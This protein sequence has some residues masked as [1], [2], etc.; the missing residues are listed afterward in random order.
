VHFIAK[1]A[2]LV[3]VVATILLGIKGL[4]GGTIQRAHAVVLNGGAFIVDEDN[5]GPFYF[6]GLRI[7]CGTAD[8]NDRSFT[9]CHSGKT[10]NIGG[11]FHYTWNCG[12]TSQFMTTQCP[13]GANY[14]FADWRPDLWYAANYN[15]CVFLPPD[16]A[17]T[18]NAQYVVYSAAGPIVKSVNQQSTPAS[19]GLGLGWYSLGVFPFNAGTGGFVRLG[20]YTGE[21]QATTQIGIDA[22]EF[23]LDGASCGSAA[24]QPD[25]DRDRV[26]DANDNC[27]SN[28]NQGQQNN[29]GDAQGDAC[30]PDDDN[31]SLADVVETSTGSYVS[32]SDTG[33]NPFVSDT[34]VDGLVDGAEVTVY[35]T[36]PTKADSDRDT[37]IDGSEVAIG[38][39]P[40][41]AG[42]P[43]NVGR[44]A[45]AVAGDCDRDPNFPGFVGDGCVDPE[46]AG[47]GLNSTNPWDFFSVPIPSLLA[48]P[49]AHR[50]AGL[51]ATD[52]QA[53]FAVFTAGIAF[54]YNGDLNANGVKDGWEYDR[55]V[56]GPAM[57]G[58][59]D[60]VL[61]ALDAQLAFAQ[62]KAGTF[63]CSSGYD[64]R[65]P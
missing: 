65:Y 38:S 47:K 11:Q 13:N 23:V 3:L 49:G 52:A 29:D 48:S 64:L 18:H 9:Y 31:D 22:V 36:D 19:L 63:N 24:V 46:E 33:T 34:D 17:Y 21:G 25:A 6:G 5:V 27:V 26:P 60:G 7:D 37:R 28:P 40:L 35:G 14:N 55:S 54:N 10:P 43:T 59:P 62:F 16:H 4:P 56:A 1:R 57:S 58:P 20:D 51:S 12:P 15:V 32:P 30:D 41:C 39:S 2:A 8:Q 45:P 42:S 53:V 61:S 44:G 50:D